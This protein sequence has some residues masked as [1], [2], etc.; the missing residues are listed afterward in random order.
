MICSKLICY[1]RFYF[2]KRRFQK[3]SLLYYTVI[4]ITVLEREV[5]CVRF[6]PS[7]IYL[8]YP[9]YNKI[10]NSIKLLKRWY[11]KQV[12]LA[13]F[14]IDKNNSSLALCEFTVAPFGHCFLLTCSFTSFI[15]IRWLICSYLSAGTLVK[16]D[17]S[18]LSYGF[19]LT[20]R[21]RIVY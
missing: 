4:F 10:F 14:F 12:L 20:K 3:N 9:P 16:A 2:N 15:F 13:K 6:S 18:T 8:V 11:T 17:P 21:M 5:K 19:L 1:P 7:R